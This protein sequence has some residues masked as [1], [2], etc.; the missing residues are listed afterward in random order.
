M[1]ESYG[2][3]AGNPDLHASVDGEDV[4]SGESLNIPE[5]KVHAL[6]GPSGSGKT[7]LMMT[8]MGYP[9]YR[10]TSG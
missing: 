10:I 4:L 6:L 5:G 1:K 3:R 2:E 9:A 7:S 8:T